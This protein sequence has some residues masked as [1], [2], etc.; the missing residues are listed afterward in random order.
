MNNQSFGQYI[1]ELRQ[2]K[3]IS[4]RELANLSGLTNSTISRI[5]SDLVKPDFATLEKLSQALDVNKE[6]LSTKCGYSEIPE[7]FIVIARKAG[8]L[9]EEQRAKIYHELNKSIDTFLNN[10]DDDE[11]D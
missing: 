10:L 7:D 4:Q 1:S 5:E 3:S 2:K 8:E 9:T 6:I 11:E